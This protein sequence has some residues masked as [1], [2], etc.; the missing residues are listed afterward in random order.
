MVSTVSCCPLCGAPHDW[1]Q[2]VLS[3]AVP[4]GSQRHGGGWQ[5]HGVTSYNAVGEAVAQ[6]AN[7][8]RRRPVREASLA[9]SYTH[10]TLPTIL[11][12]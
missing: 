2:Q 3:H 6:G 8:E 12:V 4:V 5:R 1:R 10:L 7:Y 11:R 9:V